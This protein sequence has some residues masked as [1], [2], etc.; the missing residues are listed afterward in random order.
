MKINEFPKKT[1]QK[2]ECLY[3]EMTELLK[4]CVL[5]TV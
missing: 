5:F 3:D 2:Q 4:R 1:D